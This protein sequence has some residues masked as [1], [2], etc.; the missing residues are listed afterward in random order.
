MGECCGFVSATDKMARERRD[1]GGGG[2]SNGT[3]LVTAS[4]EQQIPVNHVINSF[5]ERWQHE[6]AEA[7]G[8][9]GCR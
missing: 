2:Q 4:Q 1:R 6:A 5:L 8:I 7:D 9:H 3:R